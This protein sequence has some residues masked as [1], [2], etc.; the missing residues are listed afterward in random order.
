MVLVQQETEGEGNGTSQATVGYDEL[1]L[2][3][4]LDDAE[5]VDYIGQTN[6]TWEAQCTNESNVS[7]DLD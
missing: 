6:N 7:T 5:L 2:G 1:I 4:Q 3:G